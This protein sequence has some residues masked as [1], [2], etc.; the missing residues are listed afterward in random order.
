MQLFLFFFYGTKPW[1][2]TLYYI[3]EVWYILF[4]SLG[5]YGNIWSIN[6]IDLY[7]FSVKRWIILNVDMFE[8]WIEAWILFL[9]DNNHVFTQV[10][11]SFV[12]GWYGGSRRFQSVSTL[13]LFS[14]VTSE[15]VF[16]F[17]LF[18]L[19]RQHKLSDVQ[20]YSYFLFF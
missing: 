17:F 20:L 18:S 19:A 8:V 12:T 15:N 14:Y 13:F 16:F 3:Q 7:A 9:T 4:R 1:K 2:F 10:Q 5:K 6:S 11:P